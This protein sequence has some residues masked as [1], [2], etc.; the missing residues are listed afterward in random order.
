MAE[1]ARMR[2]GRDIINDVSLE[3]PRRGDSS[4][5]SVIYNNEKTVLLSMAEPARMRIGRDI[6]NDVSLEPPRR[7]DSSET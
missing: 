3:P 4:E 5:T 6:I 7:G 2:I 1:P